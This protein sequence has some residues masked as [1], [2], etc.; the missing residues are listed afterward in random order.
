[1]TDGNAQLQILATIAG[2]AKD[3]TLTAFMLWF[4][5]M[6][7][8]G[9]IVRREELDQ[10]NKRTSD[11]ELKSDWWRDKFLGLVDTTRESISTLRTTVEAGLA[12]L[13]R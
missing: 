10:A 5:V 4:I 11:A 1:M 12:A 3:L 2:V 9:K 8:T 7:L 13:R 6:M